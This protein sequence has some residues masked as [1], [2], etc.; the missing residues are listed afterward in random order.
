MPVT[1]DLL[2]TFLLLLLMGYVYRTGESPKEWRR[3]V[4][5]VG[6][7]PSPMVGAAIN[8]AKVVSND[9]GRP[10]ARIIGPLRLPAHP[11]WFKRGHPSYCDK[12]CSRDVK[13]SGG[14][15][16][17]GKMRTELTPT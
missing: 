9:L 7:V 15:R 1:L 8:R 16:I 10:A 6:K 13:H 14:G 11:F 5:L 4:L 12:E 2:S 17:C 3:D